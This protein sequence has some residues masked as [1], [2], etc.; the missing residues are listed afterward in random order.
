MIYF[1]ALCYL[2][3][4]VHIIRNMFSLKKGGGNQDVSFCSMD[5]NDAALEV[6]AS[7]SVIQGEWALARLDGL[8]FKFC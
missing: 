4:Y 5:C 6:L 8:F 2:R 3:L 1:T 7:F